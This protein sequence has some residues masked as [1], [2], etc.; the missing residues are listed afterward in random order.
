M[1]LSASETAVFAKCA[2]CESVQTRPVL[3]ATQENKTLQNLIY[4]LV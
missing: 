1:T 2:A 3:A 4:P